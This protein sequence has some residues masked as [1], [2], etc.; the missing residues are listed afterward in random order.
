MR[1]LY[2]ARHGAADPFGTLTDTGRQQAVLLGTR[3][4]HLPISAIWHSPLSRAASTA[5]ELARYLPDASVAEAEELIDN[6]PHV[7]SAENMPPSWAGFFDG[8][9]DA[10]AAAGQ[11]IADALTD[12]FAT[13]VHPA[14]PGAELHEVLITHDYPI[15]W[16]VR[17]ALDAPPVR[18]LDLSSANTGLTVITY[19][20][21]VAPTVMMFNDMSHLP[22][23]L[24]WTGF[25][26]ALR[27]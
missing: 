25:P 15:A 27:P 3:L 7:P 14:A 11:R 17:H 12:R 18:W 16:L 6:I 9:D 4:A 21:G 20:T 22:H 13:P 19:R 24:R 8:Y 10:E 26:P 5:S 23:E 2:I 1:H